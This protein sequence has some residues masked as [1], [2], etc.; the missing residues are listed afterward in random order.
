[1]DPAARGRGVGHALL[2]QVEAVV[3]SRGGR[4]LLIETSDTLP[5]V[6]ARR[7]Y[8]SGGYRC[9]ALVRDFYAPGDDL[10]IYT[11]ELEDGRRAPHRARRRRSSLA[12]TPRAP[13]PAP[14][15]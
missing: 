7:L 14:V 12:A 9:E 6:Q 10:L 1:M 4:L 13:S 3:R 5:Y 8:E 2:R 11:K 15:R